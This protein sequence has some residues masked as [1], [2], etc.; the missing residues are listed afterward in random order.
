MGS[1]LFRTKNV[2]Q[3]IKDTEEPEHALKKSL[4]A[5]DLTVF[6]VGVIIGTG[7]FVLTGTAAKNNA[8]PAVALSFVVAGVVCGLA[9]LCYAEFASTVPVAGSAYTFSYAS[10]GEFPAWIIGWDLV[11]ELALGT[12]VVAVGWSGYIHSLLD[13]AGWHLPG[14]LSGRDGAH[15]FGFDILAAALVLVLTAILV[16]GMKLSARVTSVVVAIKVAV[17]LVVIIAGAFFIHSGNYSPFV[18][19]KEPVPAGGNLKAPLIQLMIGWAPSNFGVMGIFT[20]ASV[21]FFAFIGFDVVATAAEETRNPQRDVPRGI[22]GS[23]I[24]CT[25]LYVAVAIVVTGMQKYSELSV[26]APLADAF[27]ATGHPW[28]AGLIS[29]GAAV[30]LTTVCMILLLGQSRVFFAMSRDGLLP[31]FFSHTHPRF[32]TPYRPT[33]L[34]GVVIAIVAGFTSLS[35][36]AEL[37][38]IGT[39]FAFIVVAISV[40][41]LRNTRPDLERSFRTPWVPALPIVS[42]LASLWLMLNLPAE[43]WLRFAIWMVIGFVVYFLYGRSHSRLAQAERTPA[44]A[45]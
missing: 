25:A 21:V 41:I 18:P 28:F 33:I 11:L 24:I 5:L 35:E 43:T 44:D 15:G 13:N 19:P 36:L 38:N 4:S 34:L 14:Y 17:V 1:T 2:E 9:A 42:V 45:P 30:G 10:L 16:V 6:G 12:A 23:L 37:V 3:S 20:A 27:K 40:I 32:R 8:G 29:F 26:D 39:L 7:I 22:I 31:R